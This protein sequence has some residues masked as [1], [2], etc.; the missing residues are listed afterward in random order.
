[1]SG[2]N[3]VK[4]KS[5]KKCEL[6][7][8]EQRLAGYRKA[9]MRNSRKKKANESRKE[10][11]HRVQKQFPEIIIGVNANFDQAASAF[12]VDSDILAALISPSPPCK[13]AYTDARAIEAAEKHEGL[14]V[15]RKQR[16]KATGVSNSKD[17][18]LIRKSWP[19]DPEIRESS[20]RDALMV[21]LLENEGNVIEC[22]KCLNLQLPEIAA[23]MSGDSELGEQKDRGLRIAVLQCEAAL[24]VQAKGGNVTAIKTMLENLASD[25]WSSRQTV[26]V[27][28]TGFRP[29]EESSGP[30]VLELIKGK[31][32]EEDSG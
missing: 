22:G 3:Q 16:Q 30:S 8:E 18:R 6:S 13:K 26:N 12:G 21:S 23:V 28:H 32:D 27:N 31:N 1:M 2:D 17:K 7:A 5:K 24:A 15:G 19:V 10:F 14:A 25:E 11:M 20:I 9:Y 4:V 29:P